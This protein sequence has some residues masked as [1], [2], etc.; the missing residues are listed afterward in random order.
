MR[1][2]ALLQTK[3]RPPSWFFDKYTLSFMNVVHLCVTYWF[4]T[5]SNDYYFHHKYINGFFYAGLYDVCVDYNDSFTTWFD[6]FSVSSKSPIDLSSMF[7]GFFLLFS[8]DYFFWNFPLC[9][10]TSFW[11]FRSLLYSP[12][13]FIY[14]SLNWLFVIF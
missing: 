2:F 9:S 12:F 4:Q 14:S 6:W 13:W 11:Y 7:G 5:Y 8:I 1:A 10:S 3:A